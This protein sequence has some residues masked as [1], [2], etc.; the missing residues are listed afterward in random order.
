MALLEF[1]IFSDPVKF[2][3]YRHCI[4]LL[5]ML[6]LTVEIRKA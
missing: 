1:N 6:E 4:D 5:F 2:I 3:K